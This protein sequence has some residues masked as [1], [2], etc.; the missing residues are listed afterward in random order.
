MWRKVARFRIGNEMKEGK[1]WEAEKEKI[2]R[3]CGNVG[4]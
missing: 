3:L 2:C 1:Y 4:E